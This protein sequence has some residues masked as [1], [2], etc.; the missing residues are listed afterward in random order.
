MFWKCLQDPDRLY[1]RW[2]EDEKSVDRKLVSGAPNCWESRAGYGYGIWKRHPQ[3]IPYGRISRQTKWAW[4]LRTGWHKHRYGAHFSRKYS[5]D[6]LEH[7]FKTSGFKI[8]DSKNKNAPVKDGIRLT[9]RT[10]RETPGTTASLAHFVRG[11]FLEFCADSS[12]WIRIPTS[13]SFRY[14]LRVQNSEAR[15]SS[16]REFSAICLLKI[17]NVLPFCC[18]LKRK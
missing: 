13:M 11:F 15:I 16:S 7:N 10:R 6:Q 18:G 17:L 8:N 4:I 12:H 1:F 14:F 2:Q 3:N 9:I 5:V